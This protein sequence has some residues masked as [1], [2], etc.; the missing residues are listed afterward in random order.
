M[1]KYTILV[2]LFFASFL[3]HQTANAQFGNMLKK[4][5]QKVTKK[6]EEKASSSIEK[7]TTSSTTNSTS[8]TNEY[9]DE[10]F[11]K[12]LAKKYPN[13]KEKQDFYFKKYKEYQQKQVAEKEALLAKENSKGTVVSEIPSPIESSENDKFKDNQIYVLN[14]T[15]FKKMPAYDGGFSDKMELSGYYHLSQYFVRN[16]SSHFDSNPGDIYEGFSIEY[17]PTS[18]QLNAYF[19]PNQKRYGVVPEKYRKS[20]D[21]G[22]IQFQFGMGGGPEWTNANVLLLE[23]G[24][25][26]IGADVYHKNDNVGHK[27]MNNA[28]PKQFVI[29]AKNPEKIKKYYKNPELTSQTTFAKFDN[30]RKDWL[31]AKLNSV[32]MPS[33]GSFDK[34][35]V[36]KNAAV[37]GLNKYYGKMSMKNIYQ[38][39]TSDKWSTVKHKVT[40][41]PLYQWAVGAVVQKNSDEQCMLQQFIVRKDYIGGGKYGSPFFNGINRGSVRAPYGGYVKCDAK[42]KN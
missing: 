1:K 5:K 42:P 8:N 38:Y 35:S 9:S 20:A 14:R 31:G 37:S 26:L 12:E 2:C 11:K 4:A 15:K 6:I 25:L 41:V 28:Q 32:T 21:K 10:E 18:Y 22:N 40:G 13:D 29:A 3:F 7:S 34:N 30:L 19:S 33:K 24:V 27:W 16:P 17:D 36:I 23:P 39:M